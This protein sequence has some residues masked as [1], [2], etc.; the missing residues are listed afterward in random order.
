MLLLRHAAGTIQSTAP[1]NRSPQLHSCAPCSFSC[2]VCAN[3]YLHEQVG[4]LADVLLQL[5][6]LTAVLLGGNALSDPAFDL[7]AGG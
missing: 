5:P 4:A 7:L 3:L 1:P 6:Q 2:F